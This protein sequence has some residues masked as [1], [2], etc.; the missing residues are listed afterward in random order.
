LEMVSLLM[1]RPAVSR[2]QLIWPLLLAG[3][4]FAASSRSAVAGMGFN[5]S[6][7]VAHF[8]VYGLL[9]TLVCRALRPDWRGALLAL[10]A[11][12]FF[13]ATDEWHQSF[14]PGRDADLMDWL[15]D[16]SGAALAVGLYF[17]WRP[18][19]ELLE[20]GWGRRSASPGDTARS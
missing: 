5:G 19:R 15:A 16:T 11:V 13:G 20:R 17:F 12:S 6:D 14:V 3:V 2:S 8:S 18:Y 10:A 1:S 7:K 9:G 4:I